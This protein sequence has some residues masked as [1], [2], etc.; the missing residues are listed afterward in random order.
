[1]KL[2][3]LLLVMGSLSLASRYAIDKSCDNTDKITLRDGAIRAMEEAHDLAD[4][5]FQIM[6]NHAAD[7]KVQAM[8]KLIFGED[9]YDNKFNAV[10]DTFAAVREF[11]PVPS[12]FRP[13]D[14]GWIKMPRSRFH[15]AWRAAGGIRVSKAPYTRHTPYA[16]EIDLCPWYTSQMAA[17]GWAK[18][19]A[20]MVE[21]AKSEEFIKALRDSQAP[22]DGLQTFGCAML[23]E[24]GLED[25]MVGDASAHYATSEILVWSLGHWVN[26]NGEIISL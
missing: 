16:N 6:T 22:I 12:Q 2:N 11:D 18:I 9:D 26:E 15:V 19:D 13:Q 23:H 5:A 25:A 21:K 8:F 20:A 17:G 1:M 4:N 7:D 10:R 24:A 3:L 14:D